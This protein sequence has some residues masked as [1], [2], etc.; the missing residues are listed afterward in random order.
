MRRMSPFDAAQ[1][2]PGAGRRILVV[3][4]EPSIVDAV[5]TALR[6]EGYE[7]DEASNG[8]DALGVVAAREPDLIVLDWMLPDLDGIEVGKRLREQGFKTA[9]LFLTAKDSTENKVEALRAGGDDY[10]TKPFSLAEIVARIQAILRRSAGDLPGDVLRVG[11]LVLD[12]S[13]HEVFRGKTPISLTATE[14]ALLRFFMLNPRRV[15]TK[16]QIL[17]NVWHY[18]FGGNANVV[19]TYVSYLRKKLDSARP[20][21]DQDGAAGR[22]HARSREA[23]SR[24]SLR[25]RLVLGVLVVAAVGL[26]IAD[27]ATYAALRSSLFDRVDQTLQDDHQGALQYACGRASSAAGPTSGR[28]ARAR[29]RRRSRRL[30]PGPQERRHDPLHAPGAAVRRGRG[31]A[32]AARPHRRARVVLLGAGAGPER[33]VYFTVPTTTGDGR[34][35]VRASTGDGEN[36]TLIVA[37]SLSDVDSTLSH[38]RRIELV[39]TIAVL[40]AIVLLGLWIVT[41]GLRPLD[42]IGRTADEITAGDLSHRVERAEPRTEV[43]RLGLALNTM[44]DRIEASDRRLRRF[45]ADASHELRTPLA[46]VSAYAELFGRGADKRPDDLARAMSGI[47]RE[48]DRMKELV[49]DLLLLAR[50]DEGQP[51]EHEPV[52]LGE[53][54]AE[55]VETARALDPSRPLD[56]QVQP[57][58][59]L[60]DRARLRRVLDNLLGNVRSH[61]PPETPAHV[62]V[63]TL[64]GSAVLEVSDDG[65]GLPPEDF[66]RVFT[67]FY[68]ADTSRS[69]ESGGVGL[70]LSIVAAI[71][72]A[73][74]GKVSVAAGPEGGATFRVELPLAPAG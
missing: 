50:L 28:A 22:L 68:R 9:I 71:A 55:A 32:E 2:A 69:R 25:A 18:D 16:G 36:F 6:Y 19:E 3:D 61:T 34:Y 65:P 52:E 48:S 63:S 7:V 21:A 27:A 49:E 45:V 13:R 66:D 51:L 14:F 46:A 4:D 37:T 10:V 39:V 43:G 53:L 54:A 31:A 74:A 67:R 20:A 1:I 29:R 15:L 41:L 26:L 47:T 56:L 58:T 57:A 70:G 8:R 30:R 24:L 17:Q 72:D 5:A 38:L 23:M 59:V 33:V 64:N 60:G 11:D 40:A 44:L 62:R 73:H 12:E 35:R 42:A